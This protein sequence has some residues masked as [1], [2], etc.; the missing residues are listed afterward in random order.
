MQRK[1]SLREPVISVLATNTRE[2]EHRSKNVPKII[3]FERFSWRHEYGEKYFWILRFSFHSLKPINS[4]WHYTF[5]DEKKIAFNRNINRLNVVCKM[6][7]LVF[8]S[9]LDKWLRC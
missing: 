8:E 7:S 4:A 6:R 3:Y 2:L 9:L 1:L 5:N